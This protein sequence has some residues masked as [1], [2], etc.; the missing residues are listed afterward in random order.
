M[1]DTTDVRGRVVKRR[2]GGAEVV[3]IDD[4]LHFSLIKIRSQAVYQSCKG[5]LTA[6][7]FTDKYGEHS[8]SYF[9]INVINTIA[10]AVFSVI[11]KAYVFETNH[12]TANLIVLK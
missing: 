1:E 6:A 10:G 3:H 7:G 12:R 11:V 8:V 9:K 4:T 5:C 2:S